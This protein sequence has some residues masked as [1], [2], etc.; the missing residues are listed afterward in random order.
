LPPDTLLEACGDH[1][2]LTVNC[3][4]LALLRIQAEGV[5]TDK[6]SLIC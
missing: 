4:R 3:E 6:A 2:A 1:E 5:W